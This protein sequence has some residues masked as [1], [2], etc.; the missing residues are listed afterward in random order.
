MCVW[1]GGWGGEGDVCG[2]M[3]ICA[4][5]GS[6]CVRERVSDRMCA[7]MCLCGYVLSE[8]VH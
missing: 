5:V 1:G 7:Y 6:E 8:G 4:C 3:S 2:C